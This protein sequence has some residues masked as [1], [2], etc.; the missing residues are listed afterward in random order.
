[1]VGE[2]TPQALLLCWTGETG[3]AQC[4]VGHARSYVRIALVSFLSCPWSKRTPA[5]TIASL[6]RLGT[7]RTRVGVR[8]VSRRTCA[9]AAGMRSAIVRNETQYHYWYWCLRYIPHNRGP[10]RPHAPANAVGVI[11]DIGSQVA[12]DSHVWESRGRYG[13]GG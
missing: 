13:K 11:L 9:T 1:M 10:F 7:R 4:V 12:F 3:P 8:S 6:K 2:L 5:T